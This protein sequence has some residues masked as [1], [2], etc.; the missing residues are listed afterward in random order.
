VPTEVRCPEQHEEEEDA[1]KFYIRAR[2]HFMKRSRR[3]NEEKDKDSQDLAV[4]KY[5]QQRFSNSWWM[6]NASYF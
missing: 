3:H 4:K 5:E 6:T 2:T 1:C